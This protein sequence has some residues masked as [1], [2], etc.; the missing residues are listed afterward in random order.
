MK[1]IKVMDVSYLSL[2]CN[3]MNCC[4]LITEEKESRKEVAHS[5]DHDINQA[6]KKKKELASIIF[7]QKLITLMFRF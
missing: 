6:S 7:K 4:T 5:K 3:P 2:I 1:Y